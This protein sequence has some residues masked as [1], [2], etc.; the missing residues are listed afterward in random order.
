K[1]ADLVGISNNVSLT[2]PPYSITLLVFGGS[3]GAVTPTPTPQ[4]NA[5][6]TGDGK[7]D[8][9]DANMLFQNWG[10]STNTLTDINR[11]G[12]INAADYGIL[13]IKWSSPTPTQII[14][15]TLTQTP[16]ITL[17]PTI[18]TPA[19]GSGL[20]G[21]YYTY[22]NA[23]KAFGGAPKLTRIDPN[24]DFI[25]GQG[26]PASS[27]PTNKFSARWTGKIVAPSSG[28]YTVYA[29][30]DDGVRVWINNQLVIDRWINQA[31][32]EVSG[33]VTLNQG[34]KYDI[35]VEYYEYNGSAQ[36]QLSWSNPTLSK[37]IIPASQFF[38][39]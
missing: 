26:S 34:V 4:Y 10:T 33:V 25:W 28:A 8:A 38:V 7:I 16:T 39:Q 14:T 1:L 11:D 13:A 21:Q 37:Q 24:I 20:T 5:D 12:F 27:L 30:S 36:V 6:I 9:L 3:G 31:A 2:I 23:N 29:K 22:S 19:T 32:T 35:K 15:P 17:T 18:T